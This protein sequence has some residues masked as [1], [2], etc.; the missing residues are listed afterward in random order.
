MVSKHLD[1]YEESLLK[2]KKEVNPDGRIVYDTGVFMQGYLNIELPKIVGK[3]FHNRFSTG[4]KQS[5]ALA[6]WGWAGSGL[7]QL[8]DIEPGAKS[9]FNRFNDFTTE[10]EYALVRKRYIDGLYVAYTTDMLEDDFDDFTIYNTKN[11]IDDILLNT[12]E[13]SLKSLLNKVF[14]TI[15]TDPSYDG[16]FYSASLGEDLGTPSYIKKIYIKGIPRI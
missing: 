11:S 16:I 10:A 14:P 6:T 4:L 1:S 13:S 9:I 5:L 12:N 8:E 2:K 3:L 7:R 15:I